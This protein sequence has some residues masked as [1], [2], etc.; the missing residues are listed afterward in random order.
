[1]WTEPNINKH[2]T[3]IL[4]VED[5]D[6]D[7]EAILRAFQKRKITNPCTVVKNGVE[8]LKL[9]RGQNVAALNRPYIILLDINMPQMNGFEFLEELRKDEALK[10]SIVFM[11]TTSN[12]D[13][14]KITAYDK[15]I[16]GYLLKSHVGKDYANLIALLES[17]GRVVEF[18]PEIASC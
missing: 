1:M 5:V 15:Q 11:L 4:V 16:A 18:S 14:D 8:A 17:Y 7:A 13:E 9:L 10:R 2:S 6:V 12:R 3:H